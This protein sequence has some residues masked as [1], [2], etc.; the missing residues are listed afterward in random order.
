MGRVSLES[1]HGTRTPQTQER[2]NRQVPETFQEALEHVREEHGRRVNPELWNQRPKKEYRQDPPNLEDYHQEM[3]S[4][5]NRQLS[6]DPLTRMRALATRVTIGQNPADQR[7]VSEPM[8]RPPLLKTQGRTTTTRAL[9]PKVT[10]NPGSHQRPVA[11]YSGF[12]RSYGESGSRLRGSNSSTKW[13]RFDVRSPGKKRMRVEAESI[14]TRRAPLIIERSQDAEGTLTQRYTESPRGAYPSG[15]RQDSRRGNGT[16]PVVPKNRRKQAHPKQMGGAKRN[17]FWTSPL[18]VPSP[19]TASTSEPG[20][21]R[22]QEDRGGAGIREHQEDK[23][24]VT[25]ETIKKETASTSD[26]Q[27]Q[28]VPG[29]GTGGAGAEVM[30][31]KS[32]HLWAWSTDVRR[33]TIASRCGYGVIIVREQGSH[34]HVLSLLRKQEVW[35]RGYQFRSLEHAFRYQLGHICH[36]RPWQLRQIRDAKTPMLARRAFELQI[37][38]TSWVMRH[39]ASQQGTIMNALTTVLRKFL[40]DRRLVREQLQETKGAYL[41]YQTSGLTLGCMRRENRRDGL[42]KMGVEDMVRGGPTV[43]IPGSNYMGRTLMSL[44]HA[45]F[46][47]TGF[48]KDWPD[49]AMKKKITEEIVAM[50]RNRTRDSQLW[51]HEPVGVVEGEASNGSSIEIGDP[52]L[53]SEQPED[54]LEEANQEEA[55]RQLVSQGEDQMEDMVDEEGDQTEIRDEGSAEGVGEEEGEEE[56][57]EL[58]LVVLDEVVADS[59]SETSNSV[60]LE[61][62]L[63]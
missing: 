42:G 41:V 60:D 58:P 34:Q 53:L 49:R 45:L 24:R 12:K 56:E 6:L 38:R 23:S 11:N 63:E 46:K 14:P 8:T 51:M 9:R 32:R 25:T 39:K 43:V 22:S 2:W 55:I 19:G 36:M 47:T 4:L 21:T 44:R 62:L 57:G 18:L 30:R 48:P 3:E 26:V 13:T 31:F 35:Y 52:N 1:L 27:V 33:R 28:G 40:A 7:R 59:S 15:S 50:S 37:S 29:C 17:Q 10:T 54:P 5:A 16:A 20:S 61:L